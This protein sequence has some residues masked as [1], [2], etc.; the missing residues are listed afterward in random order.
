M[1]PTFF[2]PSDALH[3]TERSERP[4]HERSHA[5]SP[6]KGEGREKDLELMNLVAEAEPNAQRVLA[7]RLFAR[8]RG[9]CAALLRNS[10][11]AEDAAQM[12]LVEVLRSAKSYRG[13][14]TVE[15]WSDRIVARTALR[16]GRAR[17]KAGA[18]VD[19]DADPDAIEGAATA[20]DESDAARPIEAY[21]EELSPPLR[22][23]L[24]LRHAMDCSI[25]EIAEAVGVSPNTVKDRL[26]RAREQLRKRIRRE[27]VVGAPSEKETA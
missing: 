19:D 11:D 1:K 12:G 26:L 21:L 15:R 6:P 13:D 24:V 9:L 10:A 5:P 25:D 27:R 8:T 7:T 3:A 17:R 23:V 20:P 14:A 4:A 18:M 2:R 22:E 16:L